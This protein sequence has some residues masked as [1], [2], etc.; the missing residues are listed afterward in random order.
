MPKKPRVPK[1]AEIM[2]EA[3][4][5]K[6]KPPAP[7]ESVSKLSQEHSPPRS[8]RLEKQS[9]SP[10]P[11]SKLLLKP[12]PKK[13]S[14]RKKNKNKV[15]IYNAAGIAVAIYDNNT[16]PKRPEAYPRHDIQ[17]LHS[18]EHHKSS[19]LN[20]THG[21]SKTDVAGKGNFRVINPSQDEALLLY[22]KEL[23][24]ASSGS[25]GKASRESSVSG[26]EIIIEDGSRPHLKSNHGS[27]ADGLPYQQHLVG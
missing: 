22:N 15:V 26:H 7:N 17:R 11:P 10:K 9:S 5:I 8:S 19:G 24:S 27:H 3:R 25:L 12:K 21:T 16:D 23:N 6:P 4:I 13:K 1:V 18:M 14:S 2:P 20:L